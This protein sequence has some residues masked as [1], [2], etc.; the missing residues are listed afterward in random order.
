MLCGD[1]SEALDFVDENLPF[2]MPCKATGAWAEAGSSNDN[3]IGR[4]M[5]EYWR[6]PIRGQKL[7]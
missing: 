7:Q 4:K 2:F 5:L 6:A 3:T 1:A